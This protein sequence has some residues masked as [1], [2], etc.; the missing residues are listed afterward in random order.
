MKSPLIGLQEYGQ[1]IWLD[2]ISREL[3]ASGDFR[4]L[5]EEDNVHGVT[6]NPTIFDKAIEGSSDYDPSLSALLAADPAA[7]TPA[8]LEKLEIQDIQMAADILRP[9]YDRT[10]GADGFASIEVSPRLAHDA[11]GSIAEARRLRAAVNRTNLMIKIPATDE[12]ID[13]VETLTAEGININITLMF[14]QTHYEKVAQAYL[15]GLE[16][17]AQPNQVVSVAS[18][19]ISR[20][21]TEV[22]RALQTIGTPD[23]LSLCG[24]IGIA[25]AKLIYRRFQEIFLGAAFAKFKTRGANVQRPLW[26]STG[27]KNPAYSDV[28]Y[29]EEL[30]GPHTINTMPLSTLRAF[31]DHGRPAATLE[32]AVQQ[33]EG[34][35]LRLAGLGIELAPVTE[36]LLEDGLSAFL[37]SLSQL[38]AA[39]EE[40]RKSLSSSRKIA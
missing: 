39:V 11:A 3:I 7:S 27:T 24:K 14:S 18:F 8:L 31:R 22:D 19:F 33:A 30:I 9:V 17:N 1:S 26:A 34:A 5:V 20:V 36:K 6:S 25:N 29:I 38:Q 12:G 35:L 40:K 2:T 4:R 13:A 32:T 21:D 15:R 37:A 16:R 10:S 23:A 28:L